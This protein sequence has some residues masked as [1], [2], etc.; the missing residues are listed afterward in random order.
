VTTVT[1]QPRATRREW[2]GL[3]VLA[4]PT[5]LVSIDAFVLLLALPRISEQLRP[6]SS[7]LLW[8]TDIYSFL[9][10]GFLVT[11]GT[12]GDRL[13]RRRLLL[14]GAAAFGL[15]SLLAAYAPNPA[16]LITARALLGVAGA[17]LS[18]STLALISNMFADPR[19]RAAAIGVWMACFMSGAAIG[20]VVGGLM[21]EHFWWGSVFLLAVPVMALLLALGPVLLPE[22]RSRGAGRLDPASV[23]LSLAGIMLAV[24]GLTE[25]AGGWQPVPAA[26]LLAGIA[27]CVAFVRR[28]RALSEPLLDLR[29]LAN[30]TFRA[31]MSGL[32]LST[33][34]TGVMMLFVIQYL[35][36]AEGLSPVRSGLCLVPAAVAMTVS[37]LLSPWVAR[38]I[39]PAYVIAGG[40]AIA[41]VGLVA[42]SQSDG[43]SLVVTGWAL[44]TF[45][46]GPMV[47]LSVDMVMGAA[48]PAR[49]GSA[50]ALNET[51]SQLG[52]ALGIAVLGSVGAAIYRARL[53]AAPAR[54]P[55]P[56]G[57]ADTLGD[58]V[59]VAR[60]L[61][62]PAATALLDAARHAFDAG[63]HATAGI[64]AVL[65]AGVVV[66]VVTALRH[67]RPYGRAGVADAADP[68]SGGPD[69]VGR[70]SEEAMSGG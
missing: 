55:V 56:R 37:S 16:I 70:A 6:S 44:I 49:A 18:P 52:F 38:S 40:L 14:V 50:A 15:A 29:L 10:A 63:L 43:L 58:A 35:Q 20:P 7:Q 9:L 45:G 46:S 51:G 27:L 59:A 5:L 19:Q 53:A 36:L 3:A 21:L 2:A 32:T 69:S 23:A 24:Y 1:A 68:Q 31:A 30:R 17:T 26:A 65:L 42:L 60:G 25:L 57:A 41:I 62:R 22:F 4:L 64:S 47:T 66:V 39:R 48:P 11:M 34:L 61:P 12:A 67:V 54:L 13:G 33:M 28:Q 8:I